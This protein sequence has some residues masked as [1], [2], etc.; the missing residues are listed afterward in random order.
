MLKKTTKQITL[1]SLSSIDNFIA[2]MNFMQSFL[3]SVLV[4]FNFYGNSERRWRTQV[5]VFELND[6]N[7]TGRTL[8]EK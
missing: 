3:N 4:Y 7:S 6:K 1:R 8:I 2:I 5:K